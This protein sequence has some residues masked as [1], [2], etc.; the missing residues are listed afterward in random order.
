MGD[1]RLLR[2][3]QA[4]G[5]HGEVPGQVDGRRRGTHDRPVQQDD[6]RLPVAH[7]AEVPQLP[8]AMDDRLGVAFE[9][10]D[11]WRWIVQERLEDARHVAVDQRPQKVP[12]RDDHRRNGVWT[13]RFAAGNLRRQHV[14]PSRQIEKPQPGTFTLVSDAAL[15]DHTMAPLPAS[16]AFRIPVPPNVYTRP[17]LSVG[18]PRG[19]APPECCARTSLLQWGISP[20]LPFRRWTTTTAPSS[21]TQ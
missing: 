20:S 17:L 4:R 18:V 16:S 10:A 9:R 2:D 7:D 19:P 6:P 14:I 21:T 8:V 15:R 11:Q 12:A 5:V 3:R 13:A 1:G